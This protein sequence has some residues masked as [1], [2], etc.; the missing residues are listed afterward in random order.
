MAAMPVTA[1]EAMAAGTVGVAAVISEHTHLRTRQI[2]IL[3]NDL[4]ARVNLSLYHKT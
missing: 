3:A 1:A 4:S 2:R